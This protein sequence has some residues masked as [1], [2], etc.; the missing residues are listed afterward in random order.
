MCIFTTKTW[1]SSPL[2]A[3][4]C[5]P[6][7]IH[8]LYHKRTRLWY[9]F[10][11]ILLYTHLS[12]NGYLDRILYQDAASSATLRGKLEI[13]FHCSQAS[14]FDLSF[15]VSLLRSRYL[16]CVTSQKTGAK[17]A[18]LAVQWFLTRAIIGLWLLFLIIIL[19]WILLEITFWI[20]IHVIF[21]PEGWRVVCLNRGLVGIDFAPWSDS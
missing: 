20:G 19:L 21:G 15:S 1:N 9:L 7:G 18:Q 5:L 13:S 2:V 3:K 17:E 6:E 11:Q 4:R 14:I 12:L 8:H 16:S 10:F